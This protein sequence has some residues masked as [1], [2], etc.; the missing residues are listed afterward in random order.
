MMRF[1][2]GFRLNYVKWRQLVS[3]TGIINFLILSTLSYEGIGCLKKEC[4]ADL[5]HANTG[6]DR[7]SH[8]QNLLSDL[9]PIQSF[10]SDNSVQ[11]Y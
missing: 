1:V 3:G 2:S 5:L 9:I 10:I 7:F 11:L 4:T 6:I 8:V